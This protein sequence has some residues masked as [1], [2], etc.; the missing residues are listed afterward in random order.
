M[1]SEID[2]K[3][4]AGETTSAA[5]KL[6]RRIARRLRAIY[7]S[8]YERLG[9]HE[10]VG[11]SAWEDRWEAGYTLD[12]ASERARYDTITRY[13]CR[14]ACG[15]VLDIGCGD[16]LLEQELRAVTDV[17]VVALDCAATAIARA[18]A[19]QIRNCQF[20][21]G[22]L[23]VFTTAER[24]SVVVLNEVLYYIPDAAATLRRVAEYLDGDGV[25][26]VSMWDSHAPRVIWRAILDDF[27]VIEETEVEDAQ[28]RSRSNISILRRRLPSAWPSQTGR[29]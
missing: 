15:P 19:R 6:G 23:N 11:P 20:L 4:A 14:Y 28:R 5:V 10:P 2:M 26:I 13:V 25:F 18:Q 17:P 29:L 27:E 24:F 9:S 21:T 22:D 12:R 16:G 1:K 7:S 3:T 8:L